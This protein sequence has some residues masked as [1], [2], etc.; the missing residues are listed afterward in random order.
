MVQYF[1]PHRPN[2][3][4]L[5]QKQGLP[6]LQHSDYAWPSTRLGCCIAQSSCR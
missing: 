4:N 6:V 3:T 1:T 5:F 2:Y